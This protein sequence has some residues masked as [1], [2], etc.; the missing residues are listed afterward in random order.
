[1][2]LVIVEKTALEILHRLM[3]LYGTIDRDMAEFQLESGLRC[4]AGCGKCCLTGDVQV[5]VLEMLPMAHKMFCDGTADQWLDRLSGS[6]RTGTCIVYTDN[7]PV[8]AG[9]H[10]AYYAWRPVLCRLFG[11]AAVRGRTATKTLTVC[12]HIRHNAPQEAAA[13]MALAGEAPCFANHSAN[14]Y[15]LEPVLGLRVMPINAALRQAIERLGLNFAY[16]HREG[17]RDNT[18]A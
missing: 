15:G 7:P 13:A 1:M 3:T 17:L 18:A 5:S 8:Y 11:F 6:S 2:E 14:L 16:T 12:R 9:G 4:L 10:C